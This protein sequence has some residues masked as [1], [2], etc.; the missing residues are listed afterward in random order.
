MIV[1]NTHE[2]YVDIIKRDDFKSIVD[3]IDLKDLFKFISSLDTEE[4]VPSSYW[5]PG[6]EMF[7]GQLWWAIYSYL[8]TNEIIGFADPHANGFNNRDKYK[9][10]KSFDNRFEKSLY[11]PILERMI[12]DYFESVEE[13]EGIPSYLDKVYGNYRLSRRIVRKIKIKELLNEK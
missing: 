6:E 12:P 3:S 10:R 8:A 9:S 5:T 7:C 13:E 4:W 1:I 2:A 11:Q